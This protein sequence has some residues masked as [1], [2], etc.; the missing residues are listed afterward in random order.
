MG[1][2]RNRSATTALI[3]ATALVS[4]PFLA[5]GVVGLVMMPVQIWLVGALYLATVLLAARPIRI[6]PDADLSPSDVA[7][8]AG[9]VFL[10][11]GA[12]AIV[13][14]AAR[15]TSDLIGRKRREQIIRNAG[16]IAISSGVASLVYATAWR[17]LAP[18]MSVPASIPAAVLAVLVLVAVDLG[19]LYV[20]LVA[21]RGAILRQGWRWF[22]RTGRAQLLWSL[23]AV[24]TIEVILI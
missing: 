23:A 20:L 3:L 8:V 16:A 15:I 6:H 12:V 22:V 4:L 18:E 2:T 7:I 17:D 13:A 1:G 19:Q 5:I 21:L 24:I 10:P 9:I 14:A 11:P